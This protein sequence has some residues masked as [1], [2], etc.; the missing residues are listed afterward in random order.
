MS[1]DQLTVGS[2]QRPTPPTQEEL[3]SGEYTWEQFY[4][5]MECYIEDMDGGFYEVH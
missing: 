1:K 2:R 4:D 5:E 3:E